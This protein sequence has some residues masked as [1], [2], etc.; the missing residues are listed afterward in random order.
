VHPFVAVKIPLPVTSVHVLLEI[1]EAC[2]N[3]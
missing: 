1:V 3:P 2:E